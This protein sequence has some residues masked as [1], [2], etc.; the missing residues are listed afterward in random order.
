MVVQYKKCKYK[1][2]YSD[3]NSE[4]KGYIRVIKWDTDI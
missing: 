2:I 4:F 1:E 3:K